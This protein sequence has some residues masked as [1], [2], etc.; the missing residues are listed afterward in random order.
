MIEFTAKNFK[1]GQTLWLVFNGRGYGFPKTPFE[2]KIVKIGHK[3]LE[4]NNLHGHAHRVA[5][6]TLAIDG[7]Q[8]ASPGSAYLSKE[9][10]QAEQDAEALLKKLRVVLEKSAKQLGLTVEK[11]GRAA[12]DLGFDDLRLEANAILEKKR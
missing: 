8:Y 12:A 4:V 1:V 3:W 9:E 7:G 2:Y 5:I 11:I 6:A 10:F